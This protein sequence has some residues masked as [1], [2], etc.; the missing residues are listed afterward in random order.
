MNSAIYT[1]FATAANLQSLL[2]TPKKRGI[3]VKSLGGTTLSTPIN[4]TA[5]ITIEEVGTDEL[6]ITEHPVEQGANISDHAFKLPSEVVI[7]V[8]WSDSANNVSPIQGAGGILRNASPALNNVVNAAGL[9]LAAVSAPSISQ[10]ETI[11]QQLLSLQ[12]S[13]QLF[14]VYTGKRHYTNMLLRTIVAPNDFKMENSLF[15]TLTCKQVIIVNSQTAT[16]QANVQAN[17]AA[18]ASSLNLGNSNLLP[19][20]AYINTALGIS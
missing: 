6:E 20:S 2:I 8:A 17:P 13:R 10:L 7:H 3:V 18:T 4:I 1:G 5:Q 14:D 11:Y 19:G 12:V 16:L 15:L 9:A